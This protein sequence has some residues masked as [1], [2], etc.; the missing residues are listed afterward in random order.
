MKL[1]DVINELVEE[2]GLERSVLSSIVCEGILSAYQKKY[3][4][5]NLLV[6]YD[7]K[8]GDVEVKIQKEVVATVEDE[9]KQIS[10]RKAKFIDPKVSVGETIWLSF[11][12]PIGR[13]EIH[14]TL[15]QL[16]LPADH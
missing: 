11:E 8:T 3:P 2:R 7:K 16:A 6:D 13:I 14:G 10:L 12:G 5:A 1:L 15:L 9:E 4:D